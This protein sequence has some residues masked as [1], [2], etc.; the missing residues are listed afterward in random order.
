[1]ADVLLL[2]GVGT[3]AASNLFKQHTAGLEERS[4]QQNTGMLQNLRDFMMQEARENGTIAPAYNNVACRTPWTPAK[5]PVYTW[6]A[7]SKG[8]MDR[9]TEKAYE[10]IANRREH[11]REDVE[12]QIM[13]GRQYFP[14]K[15]SQALWH[16]FTPEIHLWDQA[17]GSVLRTKHT[18]L[19][20]LP[21]NPTDYDYTDAGA[22]GKALP[23]NPELFAPDAFYFTAPGLPFRYGGNAI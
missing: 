1:M 17:D 18:Q 20:W 7:D 16:A 2:I 14:R 5:P 22:M 11:E 3:Y 4:E 6:Q 19:Q 13:R 9:T 10:L 15:V 12:E 8:P 21:N 23:P